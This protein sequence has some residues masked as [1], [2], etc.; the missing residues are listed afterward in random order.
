MMIGKTQPNLILSVCVENFHCAR[1]HVEHAGPLGSPLGSLAVQSIFT[2]RP[3]TT[4]C[5]Q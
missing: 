2:E 5:S 4:N 3:M 1:E